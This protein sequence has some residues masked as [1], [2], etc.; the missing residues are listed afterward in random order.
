LLNWNLKRL[1][2]ESEPIV[3]L[4]SQEV[5]IESEPNIIS[6]ENKSDNKINFES[7]TIINNTPHVKILKESKRNQELTR[8]N[9]IGKNN[10]INNNNVYKEKYIQYKRKYMAL[11]YKQDINISQNDYNIIM[12]DNKTDYKIKYFQYKQ[13]YITFKNLSNDNLIFQSMKSM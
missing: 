9:N 5:K 3:K 1:K 13:K 4:E 11:K 12:N 10:I 8:L 2:I 7:S 6:N